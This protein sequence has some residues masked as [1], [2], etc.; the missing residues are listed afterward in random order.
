MTI[1]FSEAVTGFSNADVT[2]AGGT[3]GSLTSSDGGVTWTATFTATDGVETNGSVTVTGAY[4]DL[5]LN[6]GATG[7]SDRVAIDTANPTAT[8]DIADSNLSDSDNSSL[9]TITFSEAVTGFDAGDM[10][11]VGGS[12]AAWPGRWRGDL[13]RDLHRGPTIRRHGSVTVSRRLHRC[14]L[15]TPA[16]PAPATASI[17]TPPIRPRRSTSSIATLSD[18]D[19]SSLVT[20]TFSEAVTGVRQRGRDGGAARTFGR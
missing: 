20:I 19:N 7:A 15:A 17:S 9:V 8:I 6:V 16:R 14:W 1:T 10:T 2:V 5:A 18:S 4:T 11:V 13:D 3:L 12:L